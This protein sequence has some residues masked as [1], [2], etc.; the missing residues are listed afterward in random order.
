MTT[1]HHMRHPLAL[2]PPDRASHA[3]PPA[4][5]DVPEKEHSDSPQ[6]CRRA[7]SRDTNTSGDDAGQPPTRR[8]SSPKTEAP[9]LR[10]GKRRRAN[11][12]GRRGSQMRQRARRARATARRRWRAAADGGRA[13]PRFIFNTPGE[14][15]AKMTIPPHSAAA[16]AWRLEVMR[17]NGCPLTYLEIP[18]KV[19]NQSCQCISRVRWRTCTRYSACVA[20]SLVHNSSF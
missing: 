12:S 15:T 3:Q 5:D 19:P 6:R 11:T 18:G 10:S 4:P 17:S 20:G 2:K 8:R 16:A 14:T 7:P 9:R 1:A 13:H